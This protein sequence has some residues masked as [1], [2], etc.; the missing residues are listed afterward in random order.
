MGDPTVADLPRLLV[1]SDVAVERTGAGSLLLYRLLKDYPADRL[2]IVNNPAAAHPDPAVRLPGIEY[3]PLAYH[4]P[5]ALRNRFNPFWPIGVSW[6]LAR[7]AGEV[8]RLLGGFVPQVVVSVT[9]GYLWF[10]AAAVARRC[11]A[12]LLLFLHEDW[13]S[14][15]TLGKSGPVWRLVRAAASARARPVLRQAAGRFS[16]SPGMAAEMRRKYGLDSEVIYPNRGED[17]PTPRVRVR[18]DPGGPPVVAHAGFVHLAGNAALLSEVADAA[19]ALGGRLD[20]Y[21]THTE[22]ELA[23][24]GLTPPAA[25][26]VGFFPAAEMASRL[27]STAHALVVTASFDPADRTHESTL[28]PSKLADYTGVGLPLIVWG[29]A[30]SSAARWAAENPGAALL[31]AAPDPAPVRAAI[32]RLAADPAW[33]TGLAAGAVEAGLRYFE[34]STARRQFLRALGARP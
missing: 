10:T 27:G 28:F 17:S 12:R 21:T 30:Y 24:R 20:L 23:A 3:L 14:L 26:R 13:P 7:R 5:R 6:M 32:Q 29:P 1:M 19:A 2:R 15:V 33:A 31:F 16:V 11:G 22:G 18:P 4:I 34:L 25:Q 8:V 9:H